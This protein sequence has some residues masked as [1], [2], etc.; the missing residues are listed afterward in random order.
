MPNLITIAIPTYNRPKYLKESLSSVVNQSYNDTK[1]VVLDNCSTVNIKKVVDSFKDSRITY[2]RHHKNIGIIK[3]WN[4]AI[5]TCRTK[6]LSIFHD[7]DIMHPLF[8][9]K[10]ITNL[11]NQSSV[12]FLYTQANKVTEKLKYIS[13]WSKLYPNTGLI[14]GY[15]YLK[16]TI[17]QG[18]CITI[19]PTVVF[20]ICVFKTV[21]LF[22]DD[23]CYNSFD[24]NMWIRIASKFDVYFIKEILVDYRIHKKQMSEIYW[25]SKDKAKGRLATMIEL[26]QA[27]YYLYHLTQN[28]RNKKYNDYYLEKI[29]EFTLMTAKYSRILI[30]DL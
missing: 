8:I 18:C 28:K 26:Y 25:R 19:A 15:D 14:K 27:L 7:D 11:E 5:D 17:D 6:Y 16:Y 23:L 22:N 3:N 30:P 10:A 12:G 13:I 29:K 2:I 20:P 21:G 4:Y 24:F 9:E 1:I